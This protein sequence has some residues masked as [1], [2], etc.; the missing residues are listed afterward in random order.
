MYCI[1]LCNTGTNTR[2][3]LTQRSLPDNR[4]IKTGGWALTQGWALARDNAVHAD[5]TLF[6]AYF[7]REFSRVGIFMKL[8]AVLF[9]QAMYYKASANVH[10]YKKRRLITVLVHSSNI[11][12]DSCHLLSLP[13]AGFYDINY[14]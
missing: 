14:R 9:I 1:V 7:C 5:Y 13:P 2:R 6:S 8:T 10:V 12:F 11:Y 3:A 4:L